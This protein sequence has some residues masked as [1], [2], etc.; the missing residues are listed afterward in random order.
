MKKIIR[1]YEIVEREV[2]KLLGTLER[3][4]VQFVN[5]EQSL[6]IAM[7]VLNEMH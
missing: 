6:D 3:E 7:K 2:D 4:E 1:N 5:Y